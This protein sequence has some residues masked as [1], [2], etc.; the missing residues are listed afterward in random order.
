MSVLTTGCRDIHA[1]DGVKAAFAYSFRVLDAVHLRVTL[2]DAV[3]AAETPQAL[4]THYVVTGVGAPAGGTVIFPSP[5][6]PNRHVVI[7]RAMPA[8]DH[9]YP[10]AGAEPALDRLAMLAQQAQDSGGRSVRFPEG[11]SPSLS[12][13][14]PGAQARAGKALAFDGNGNVALVSLASPTFDSGTVEWAELLNTPTTLAGF[15]ILDAAP[16]AHVGSGG[17][18]HAPATGEGAGFLSAADKRKLDGLSASGG[19][20]RSVTDFGAVGSGAV[21]DYA[22]IQAA[23]DAAS[24]GGTIFFPEGTYQIGSTLMIP[25]GV[26]LLGA[27]H[28][29]VIRAGT[30]LPALVQV[31]G[32]GVR[33]TSL[34][35]VNA[36]GRSPKGVQVGDPLSPAGRPATGSD[37]RIRDCRFDGF[38]EAVTLWD[39]EALSVAESVF[40]ACTTALR[41]VE[42]GADSRFLRNRVLGGSPCLLVEGTAAGMTVAGN[43]LIGS[44]EG[45]RGSGIV[46]RGGEGAAILGNSIVEVADASDGTAGWGIRLDGTDSPVA[47]ATVAGNRILSASSAA[48]TGGILL[49]G[50]CRGVRIAGNRIGGFAGQGV[51]AVGAGVADAR[52][53]DNVFGGIGTADIDL[54]G[55]L[56]SLVT[57]NDCRA[58]GSPAARPLLERSDATRSLVCGNRFGGLAPT[59][60]AGSLYRDNYGDDLGAA[61]TGAA[62]RLRSCLL[63]LDSAQRFAAAGPLPDPPLPPDPEA[64]EPEEPAPV[65]PPPTVAAC[66]NWTASVWDSDGGF[67]PAQPQRISVPAWA[68]FARLSMRLDLGPE[69]NAFRTLTIRRNGSAAYPGVGQV[70]GWGNGTDRDLVPQAATAWVPVQPGDWFDLE[71]AHACLSDFDALP[72]GWF[73]AEFI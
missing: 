68:R 60:S 56:R 50:D 10:A 65:P 64:P 54:D 7:A 30:T 15:G 51:R 39:F 12:A 37:C 36:A 26:T 71:L 18:A 62:G 29:A 72:G 31:N 42:N 13:L 17:D 73:Q 1:A 46:L 55:A 5:P 41:I 25:A 59:R 63:S 6:P 69:M 19:P 32:D 16:L 24:G 35:F 14:L 28:R 47:G 40:T 45:S 22:A 49:S 67:D 8:G 27:S 4:N 44:A 53:A 3:T 20:H 21:N 9:G 2:R 66:V 58:D 70:R 57:G 11:D 43:V 34:G 23:I 48:G 33:I 38:A 52:I 61:G